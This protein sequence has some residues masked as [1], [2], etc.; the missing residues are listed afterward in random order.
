MVH[1]LTEV[2]NY[3]NDRYGEQVDLGQRGQALDGIVRLSVRGYLQPEQ[4]TSESAIESML[5][6]ELGVKV[7]RTAVRQALAILFRDGI[8]GQRPQYGVWVWPVSCDEMV[9]VLTL[10]LRIES[11]AIETLVVSGHLSSESEIEVK[12]AY[13]ALHDAG[14]A[15]SFV[16]A[17]GSLHAALIRATDVFL[18]ARTLESWIPRTRIFFA[19]EHAAKRLEAA[20]NELSNA[21]GELLELVFGRGV[22]R[23]TE[24]VDSYVDLYF[25][26]WLKLV[27]AIEGASGRPGGE[28][29]IEAFGPSIVGE[30]E[31]DEVALGPLA[32]S[33]F[34]R[35]AGISAPEVF[36]I[37]KKNEPIQETTNWSR[38]FKAHVEKLKSNDIKQVAE[39]VRSLYQRDK[40]KGLAAGEKRMLNKARQILV[41]ELAFLKK[42]EK[43]EA[44]KMLDDVLG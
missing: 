13:V 30:P 42:V 22:G 21:N 28:R 41:S 17:E 32:A 20:R 10:R 2:R 6:D 35:D 11:P 33:V 7:N 15:D 43:V 5:A 12:K 39:V 34:P 14:D 40:E 18:G 27:M 36:R 9:E 19:A 24:K 38:R 31:D 23:A 37:L 26:R 8:V 25:E 44:E 29:P 1:S 16:R 4:R 3:I